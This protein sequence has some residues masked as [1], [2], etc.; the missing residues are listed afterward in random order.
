MFTV[1]L[2]HIALG[3]EKDHFLQNYL[4]KK[5][6]ILQRMVMNM[7]LQQADHEDAAG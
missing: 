7:V 4:T 1:F 2:K 6:K 3:L 5:E